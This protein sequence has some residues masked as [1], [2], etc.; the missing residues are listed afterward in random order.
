MNDE[1][2]GIAISE[3]TTRLRG[4][5]ILDAVTLHI[6]PGSVHALVGMN[7]AGKTTLMRNLLGILRI[8]SGQIRLLGSPLNRLSAEAWS[9]IGHMIE[10]PALYPEFTVREHLSNMFALR[11]LSDTCTVEVLNHT[12]ERLG[13]TPWID[14]RTNRLSLGTRQKVALA[15]ALGPCPEIL[16]LDEPANALDPIAIRGLRDLIREVADFGGAVLISS[17]HLDELARL[18]DHVTLLHRGSIVGDLDTSGHDL[19]KVF[20][21]T[22]LRA[23]KARQSKES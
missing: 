8:D 6:K 13:L 15:A 16:I 1:N 11:G 7:G 21:E 4:Q 5:T 14:V 10:G 9:R 22:I 2:N 12:V 18:A 20:F 3:V 17:H 23:D 19:E